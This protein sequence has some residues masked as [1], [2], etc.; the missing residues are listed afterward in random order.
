MFVFGPFGVRGVC[1]LVL[2][3]TG[4]LPVAAGALVAYGMSTSN[5]A[6]TFNSMLQAETPDLVRGPV[7]ASMDMLWQTGRLASLALGAVLAGTVGVT[8]VYAVGGVLLLRAASFGLTLL[9]QHGQ[10]GPRSP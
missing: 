10:A 1:D 8:V 2:A 4:Q 7:F 5:G 9:R 6:V 3:A